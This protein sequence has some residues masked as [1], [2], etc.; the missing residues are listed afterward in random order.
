MNQNK[1]KVQTGEEKTESDISLNFYI[2]CFDV[3]TWPEKKNI[4]DQL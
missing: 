4:F 2:I 1:T 3:S